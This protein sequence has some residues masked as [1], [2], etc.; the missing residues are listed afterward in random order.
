[1]RIATLMVCSALAASY[2]SADVF[3]NVPE[4][5]AEGFQLLYDLSIPVDGAFVGA[6]PV[7]YSTDNSATAPSFDRVGY[8]LELTNGAGTQWV[9]VSAEAFARR[10]RGRWDLPHNVNNPV[11]FQQ[12]LRSMNVLSNVSAVP[13]GNGPVH[14]TH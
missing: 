1:M 10:A 2:A 4:V 12:A 3:T 5:N 6:T 14:G 13:A 8:Y 9:Y 7:P 11:V